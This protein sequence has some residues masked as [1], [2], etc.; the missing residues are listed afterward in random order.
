MWKGAGG[1]EADSGGGEF[2]TLR[3]S[4]PVT[5]IL[6]TKLH[7]TQ[8]RLLNELRPS[9]SRPFP[10]ARRAPASAPQTPCT[11]AT[12]TRPPRAWWG[13]VGGGVGWGGGE[14]DGGG[15]RVRARLLPPAV[16]LVLPR[17]AGRCAR[18]VSYRRPLCSY[19]F[20]LSRPVSRPNPRPVSSPK[21]HSPPPA[22]VHPSYSSCSF[23]QTS[24][25]CDNLPAIP[26]AELEFWRGGSLCIA[27]LAGECG[28]CYPCGCG[29]G[30]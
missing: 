29:A 11:T 9:P 23:N 14:V 28:R 6:L 10:A 17:A 24:A 8:G 26:P 5:R 13:G 21:R 1:A 19:C 2:R 7:P 12:F 4:D 3:S 16:V 18:A 25:G 27:N 30:G 15:S 20:A 22:C